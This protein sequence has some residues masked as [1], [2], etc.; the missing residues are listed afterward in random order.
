MEPSPTRCGAPLAGERRSRAQAHRHRVRR[1]HIH[2]GATI[3]HPPGLE[4]AHERKQINI[5]KP[6]WKCTPEN[7]TKEEY[8][9]IYKHAFND[10]ENPLAVKHFSIEGLIEFHA[11]LFVPWRASFDPKE[12]TKKRNTIK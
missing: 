9:A 5:N 8:A 12:T 2:H 7:V 1:R 3:G 4:V 6:L 10:W 11:V